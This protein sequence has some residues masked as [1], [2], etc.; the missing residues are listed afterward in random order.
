M[1]SKNSSELNSSYNCLTAVSFSHCVKSVVPLLI[2]LFSLPSFLVT[3]N[4]GRASCRFPSWQA[5]LDSLNS[6][7]IYWSLKIFLLFFP[8]GPLSRSLSNPKR[9]Q[10]LQWPTS[11]IHGCL[12]CT[13]VWSETLNRYIPSIFP[14]SLWIIGNSEPEEL[15]QV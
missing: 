2:P 11:C 5:H 7:Q 6:L 15:A 3:Q 4:T 9:K 1:K 10:Q 14:R 12:S 8:P 13:R